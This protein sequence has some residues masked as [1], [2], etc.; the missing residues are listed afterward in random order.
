[1]SART[2]I[3]FPLDPNSYRNRAA[4]IEAKRIA[5]LPAEQRQIAIASLILGHAN[6]DVDRV[7][8]QARLAAMS[9]GGRN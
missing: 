4:L 9:G 1:M 3:R 7:A 2:V 5:E 6:Q 8:F